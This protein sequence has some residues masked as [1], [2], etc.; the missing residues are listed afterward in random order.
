[1]WQA[2]P[3][4]NHLQGHAV[5][6]QTRGSRA[7]LGRRVVDG[8]V[9]QHCGCRVVDGGVAAVEHNTTFNIAV[10]VFYLD[11]RHTKVVDSNS[12]CTS[13][14]VDIYANTHQS[15]EPLHG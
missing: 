6:G 9:A 1:M 12:N 15:A 10:V 3:V 11:C 5:R 13:A 2:S 8:G 4:S 14:S 7:V